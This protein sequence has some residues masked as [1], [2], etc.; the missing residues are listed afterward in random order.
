LLKLFYVRAVGRRERLKGKDRTGKDGAAVPPTRI[1]KST[2]M[3]QS[4]EKKASKRGKKKEWKSYIGG[5][6]PNFQQIYRERKTDTLIRDGRRSRGS[7]L[8]IKSG[9]W[10]WITGGWRGRLRRAERGWSRDRKV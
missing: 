4:P 10:L 3:P 2:E 5:N 8:N 1:T 9:E 6:D 7:E